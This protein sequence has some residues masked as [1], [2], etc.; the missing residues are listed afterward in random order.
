MAVGGL[1]YA[2][3]STTAT[4]KDI[5]FPYLETLSDSALRYNGFVTLSLGS[6]IKSIG[7]FAIANCSTLTTVTGCIFEGASTPIL[8]PSAFYYASG[9][10][11]LS[12]ANISSIH[13]YV[14]ASAIKLN[15]ISFCESNYGLYSLIHID[16]GAFYRCTALTTISGLNNVEYLSYL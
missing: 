3:G 14:F 9:L 12:I 16:G 6:R 2:A 10:L 7:S 8:H 1:A 15:T 5:S 13:S 4:K 11:S